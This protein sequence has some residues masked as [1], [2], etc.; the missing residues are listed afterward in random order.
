MANSWKFYGD[1]PWRSSGVHYRLATLGLNQEKIAFADADSIASW[2]VQ[3]W[4]RTS[5][6]LV[7]P[8]MRDAS[9]PCVGCIKLFRQ[10]LI[11]CSYLGDL[12]AEV[13]VN[14]PLHGALFV[15][16]KWKLKC[17]V[18]RRCSLKRQNFPECVCIWFCLVA[19]YKL[20]FFSSGH[21]RT[22]SAK[23][24]VFIKKKINS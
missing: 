19:E 7:S 16:R 5:R 1:Q 23:R 20:L 3:P 10:R 14:S 8:S 2:G 15:H 24:C 13:K 6:P 22:V 18:F 21:T 12:S 4:M 11:V 17:R 9:M